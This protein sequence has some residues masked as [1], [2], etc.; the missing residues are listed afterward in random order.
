MP[1]FKPNQ[2]C[3]CGS[4][5]K[6]K[7]CHGA[8]GITDNSNLK[9]SS[10]S[11]ETEL[12]GT[13]GL[14][15][16]EIVMSFLR[17]YADP[18]DSRNYANPGGANGKYKVSFVLTRPNSSPLKEN[19]ITIDNGDI[20]GDSH[21]IVSDQQEFRCEIEA[22]MADGTFIFYGYANENGYLH[23]IEIDEL[24]ATDFKNAMLSAYNALAPTLS[25]FSVL[26]DVPVHIFQTVV[27][28][29]AT[30]N[31]M[32]GVRLPFVER[33][34]PAFSNFQLDSSL[35]QFTSL[36]REALNSNSPNYQF[37]CFYKIIEGIR[38]IR[39]AR[40]T[41]ENELAFACGETPPSRLVDRLPSS[42]AELSNWLSSIFRP[43]RWSALALSQAFPHQA[44]GRK[45]N[46]LIAPSKELDT[47]RNKIA[48]AIL[49]DEAQLTYSF[50]D[51]THTAEVHGW[52]PLCKCLA[53]YLLRI[54]YP[55]LFSLD[56]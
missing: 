9:Q 51:A 28:E 47:V 16:S 42:E 50:D 29:L 11:K 54:E 30:G 15:G 13:W 22:V 56:K 32:R 19:H 31:I 41:K 8:I 10:R 39:E 55:Q 53:V 2:P 44:R 33:T 12:L 1:K 43:Q 35:T 5:R 21:I 4:G 40:T 17:H 6:F 26:R 46:D 52:L 20:I 34:A 37:L 23:K 49:R 36:Y 25:R 27:I 38:K 18:N 3:H 48:H 7:R 45:I 24:E 14:P